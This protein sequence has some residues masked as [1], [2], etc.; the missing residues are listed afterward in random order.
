MADYYTDVEPFPAPPQALLAVRLCNFKTGSST[1][2]VSHTHW[3]DA[4]LRDLARSSPNPW[5]DFNGYASH[6]GDPARNMKLSLDRCEAV[7]RY[8]AGYGANISFP[9]RNEI[10]LGSTQSTGDANNDDGRWRSVEVFLYGSKPPRPSPRPN[11]GPGP[12]PK[13][14]GLTLRLSGQ[15]HTIGAKPDDRHAADLKFADEWDSVTTATMKFACGT[16]R[17]SPD[18]VLEAT[19]R[20]VLAAA[21]AAGAVATG[22][23]PS[24]GVLLAGNGCV[25]HFISGGG[26]AQ[27][28]KPGD[29][30][31]DDAATNKGLR[32][33]LI[34]LCEQAVEE[35]VRDAW[36]KG[37]IDDV[38]IASAIVASGRLNNLGVRMTGAFAGFIGGIHAYVV[39]LC[40]LRVDEAAQTFSYKFDVLLVDHFGLDEDDIENSSG[41]KAVG[42][43]MLSFFVLQHFS[44]AGPINRRLQ[45]YKPFLNVI[46]TNIGAKT[47]PRQKP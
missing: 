26:S 3:L 21:M 19:M 35:A 6:L 20:G 10:P 28:F 24:P 45:R 15:C 31:A 2:L 22:E 47:A 23:T 38:A 32:G 33:D 25:D 18:D 37:T 17:L 13:P 36:S 46:Q 39:K 41:G 44:S 43:S 8:L 40:D 29:A 34:A 11:P 30:V 5:V 16:L 9:P 27:L 42:R 14:S 7:K 4:N 1:P 12:G